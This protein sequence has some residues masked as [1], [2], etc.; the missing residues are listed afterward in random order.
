MSIRVPLATGL[1]SAAI[2]GAA[3][4]CSREP[5]PA[6]PSNQS[7]HGAHGG[8]AAPGAPRT[9]LLGDLGS[10]HRAIKTTSAD[11][12]GF[13]DE[14]LT[15]LYGFN[16]E[17]SFRSFELSAAKDPVSPMPHWGMALALGTNINDTAPAE[18]LK[19][20]YAHLAEAQKRKSAGSEVEQGLI[21]AL[22]K[23]Y[24]AEPTGDQA[25]REQAYADAMG[26]LARR[27]PDDLDVATLYAESMM[28]LRP[29]RLY[30]KD[31]TPEPGTDQ[32]VATLE[33][34]MKRDPNHPGA[35]H[36]YIHA[37][38]ASK[39]P[40]RA[41]PQ[42]GR[43]ESLVPG[44]GHLVHMPAH[45][46]IRTGQYAKSAK[47]NAD[48][49]AVDEKY[50]KA[51]GAQGMYAAMYYT[52]NLQFES[53]AAMYAGNFA[54]AR[55]AAQR[56][57]RIAD[58]IADQMVMI[59]PFAAQ[60]LHVLVRFG[61]WDEIIGSKP[62]PATRLLQTALYHFARGAALAATGK[63]SEA[64]VDLAALETAASKLPKDAMVG[65]ANSGADVLAVA[66][67]DLS[68][69]IA[70]AKGDHAAAIKGFT[71]AVAAEDQ[72]GYNEPPDWLHPERELLGQ[73]LLAARRFAEAEQV[74]RADLE[75]NV[76]NPRALFGVYRAL[77][78]QRKPGAAAAKAA[79][80]K[81][82]AGAD[83]TL[84]YDTN[85]ARR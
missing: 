48:A 61:R 26:A 58:P 12:Q 28:N 54:Q 30:T 18:R 11:A 43:L 31:G 71:A 68:A 20:G 32:I 19:Q 4:S 84:S 57:V 33:A 75:R 65:A 64:A 51:T 42:A 81:A 72:L 53:A 21:D 2:V 14:G 83:V 50:F 60:E 49:A 5:A 16:H 10:Y 36:Y 82:W 15:L 9:T 77:E 76:G 35:N 7:A 62:P 25:V 85:G 46:Y 3:L 52:H 39:T 80:D 41:L 74:F 56:T 69:R 6:P 40:E 44:A 59:E 17:E 78:A 37:V 27:F 47:S 13:F 70:Q 1:L 34:V 67:A 63:P 22:A 29:W 79:F 8:G 38:E 24:V 55:D 23:R 66:I 73:A 45:V